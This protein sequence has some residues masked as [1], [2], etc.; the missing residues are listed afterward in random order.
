MGLTFKVYFNVEQIFLRDA[1]KKKR[2]M[3]DISIAY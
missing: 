2:L 3:F 1:L